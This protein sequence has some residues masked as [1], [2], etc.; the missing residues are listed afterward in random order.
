MRTPKFLKIMFFII[1]TITLISI[2]YGASASKAN[3][4]GIEKFMQENYEGS[5]TDFRDAQLDDPKSPIIAHNLGSALYQQKRYDKSIEELQKGLQEATDSTILSQIYYNIGNNYFR[6][7][8][9]TQSIQMYKKALQYRPKDEDAK[10]NLE[11][12]RAL[13][14]ESAKKKKQNKQQQQKQQQQKQQKQQKKQQEKDKEQEEKKKEQQQK[15]QQ[16]QKQKEEEQKKRQKPKQQ[17]KKP[18]EMTKDEAKQLLKALEDK[19]KEEQKKRRK[20]PAGGRPTGK[21]W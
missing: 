3:E 1:I 2:S 16:Q 7:D 5:L 4:T 20:L 10:Y 21:N 9:L 11:L 17:K 14:K 12:A 19:E 8:S 13:L 15:Q 18:E 6:K